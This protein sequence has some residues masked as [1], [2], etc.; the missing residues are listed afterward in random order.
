MLDIRHLHEK[1]KQSGNVDEQEYCN[2]ND[3]KPRQHGAAFKKVANPAQ[4]RRWP[5]RL[6]AVKIEIII[7]HQ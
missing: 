6:V 4:G 7:T 2:I 5:R 1:L 3:D